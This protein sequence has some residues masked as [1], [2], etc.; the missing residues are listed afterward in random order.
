MCVEDIRDQLEKMGNTLELC[1]QRGV[2]LGMLGDCWYVPTHTPLLSLYCVYLSTD[3][4][5]YARATHI[6]VYDLVFLDYSSFI[7]RDKKSAVRFY[8]VFNA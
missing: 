8:L 2:V 1:S 5:I 6:Y 4:C 7:L 3:A